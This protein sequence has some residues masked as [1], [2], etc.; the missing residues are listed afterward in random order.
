MKKYFKIIITMCLAL[1]CCFSLFGCN[2]Q[3]PTIEEPGDTTLVFDNYFQ[4][5]TKRSKDNTN[6]ETM[7]SRLNRYDEYSRIELS[8]KNE[9]VDITHFSFNLTAET[10][11]N[12]EIYITIRFETQV[13]NSE[14]YLTYAGYVSNIITLDT[15]E[16]T[17]NLYSVQSGNSYKFVSELSNDDTLKHFTIPKHTI[18]QIEFGTS[19]NNIIGK[20]MTYYKQAIGEYNTNISL[21]NFSIE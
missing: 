13:E 18:V 7:I 9:D 10:D 15:E 17:V 2:S 3:S 12:V 19:L 1:M 11:T 14:N 6:D 4:F 8:T 16:K 5:D 21:T 20:Q